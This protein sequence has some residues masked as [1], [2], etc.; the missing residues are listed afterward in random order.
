MGIVL[1]DRVDLNGNDMDDLE[2]IDAL[3]QKYIDENEIN[4]TE[5]MIEKIAKINEKT[6]EDHKNQCGMFDPNYASNMQ[7]KFKKKPRLKELLF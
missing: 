2:I 7:A 6:K 1:R 3:V 4:I 5:R